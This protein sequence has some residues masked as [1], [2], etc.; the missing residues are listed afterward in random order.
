[1]PT[2]V[3]PLPTRLVESGVALLDRVPASELT[4]RAIAREAGVSHGAPRRYF[5]T[6]AELLSAVAAHGFA[7]LST[8]MRPVLDARDLRPRAALAAAARVYV[9][10]AFARPGV[11]ELMARH[12]LL[13]SREHRLRKT[14]RAFF[15]QVC[16]L[17]RRAQA[18]GWRGDVPP[19]LLAA[20]LWASVHG[21]TQTWLW[22]SL[23]L[24][25]GAAAID[26]ILE[27][28]LDGLLGADR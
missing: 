4:L 11:F 2:I 6:R 13:E 21:L 10:F 12:D 20:S 7:L 27:I 26:E 16:G 1:M 3:R 9:E 19:S 15:E 23:P 24:V 8:A 25:T 18:D 14:S 28:T 5:S 17:V 22:G